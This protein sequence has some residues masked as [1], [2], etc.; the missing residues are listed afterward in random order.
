MVESFAK[1]VSE[2]SQC[3]GRGRFI[4]FLLDSFLQ[5]PDHDVHL[6]ISKFVVGLT[7]VN[8]QVFS[9][10]FYREDQ[11]MGLNR[12]AGN[13][14]LNRIFCEGLIQYMMNGE[15]SLSLTNGDVSIAIQCGL[16]F[17]EIIHENVIIFVDIKELAVIDCLRSLI[18]FRDVIGHFTQ[19]T[20]LSPNPQTVGFMLEYLVAFGLIASLSRTCTKQTHSS[21]PLRIIFNRPS[22]MRY[23]SQ[24]IVVDLISCISTMTSFVWFKSSL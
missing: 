8:S 16:G 15:A 7:D 19:T 4:A 10:R 18:P 13:D 24:I 6:A 21:I 5:D 9:M 14:T 1:A 3:H 17:C 22:P 20:A 11:R 23:I 12:V 2:F